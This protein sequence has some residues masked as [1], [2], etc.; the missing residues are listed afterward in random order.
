MCYIFSKNKM[1][2]Y[3]KMKT[4]FFDAADLVFSFAFLHK[5]NH[6]IKKEKF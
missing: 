4:G 5:S 1:K 3:E 2:I 6:Q